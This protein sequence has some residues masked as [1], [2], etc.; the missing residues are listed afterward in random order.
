MLLIPTLFALATGCAARQE[1]SRIAPIEQPNRPLSAQVRE[2]IESRM[3]RSEVPLRL[4]SQG[5]TIYASPLLPRFYKERDYRPGWSDDN[6]SLPQVDALLKAIREAEAE[7]LRPEDYHISEIHSILKEIRRKQASDQSGYLGIGPHQDPHDLA[8]LDILLTDALLLYGSHLLGGRI[9][10]ETVDPSWLIE[11]RE[12]DITETLERALDSNRIEEALKGLLPEHPVYIGLKNT[13]YRYRV[14]ATRGGWPMVPDGP[15]M[16]KGDRGHRVLALRKRLIVGGDLD[17]KPKVDEELFDHELENALRE[18][19]RRHGLQ[20]DGV[21]GPSTLEALN[22]PVERRI[23]QIELNMERW[24]WLPQYMGRRYVVVNIPSFELYVFEDNHTVI[25]M[26]VIVGKPYWNTPVFT[27]N[28]TYLVLNPHWNIPPTIFEEETLPRIQKDPGYLSKDRIRVLKG[29]GEGTGE[30]DPRTIDWSRVKADR[31]NYRLRQEPGPRNPLGQIKFMFPN[32]FNVY[33]HDTPNKGLFKKTERNFSHGCI[34][35]ER[36]LDL[37]EYVLRSNPDWT[38]QRI[39]EEIGKGKTQTVILEESIPVYVLYFTAWVD[40]D[41]T[42]E[43]RD[44]VYGR[45]RA[46]E[47]ALFGRPLNT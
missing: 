25:R 4:V 43:F 22:V 7:G 1:E 14:I 5:K 2:V 41:G 26:R 15:K 12:R 11:Q 47:E 19:Q 21:V 8:E 10:P 18:F 45:D 42:I 6:G 30:I 16:K 23:G 33:L 3:R 29:W 40:D 39:R 34:R 46:L 17:E 37:A 20:P 24:R 32:E 36:P 31:F 9:N 28:M 38:R 27:S 35:I 44:D 13:L